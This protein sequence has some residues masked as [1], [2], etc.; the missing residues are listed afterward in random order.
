MPRY[1]FNLVDGNIMS[2]YGTH[3]LDD[4]T[5]AQTAALKLAH[6]LSDTRPLSS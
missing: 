2:D 4:E 1:N 6:S 5:M 3:E